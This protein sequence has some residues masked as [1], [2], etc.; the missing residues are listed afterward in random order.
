MLLK[1]KVNSHSP[2]PKDKLTINEKEIQK[3]K[4]PPPQEEL[5]IL[6]SLVVEGR[7]PSPHFGPVKLDKEEWASWIVVSRVRDCLGYARADHPEGV[8]HG[9]KKLSALC[10]G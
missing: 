10:P 6:G 2:T 7:S 1:V 5:G 9:R 4:S 3:L 8:H